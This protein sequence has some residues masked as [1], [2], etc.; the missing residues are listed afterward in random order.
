[1]ELRVS[2]WITV[3]YFAYLAGTGAVV[4]GIGRQRRFRAMGTAIA[5]VAGVFVVE[6]LGTAIA[7]VS[8]VFTVAAFAT[9]A[10]VWRDWMPPVY[11]LLG[12][13]L[14]ALLVTSTNEV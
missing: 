3:A 1:M 5:V 11:I 14:P 7:G 4:R 12:Y 9:P 13:R 2:E 6:R 8:A 10:I